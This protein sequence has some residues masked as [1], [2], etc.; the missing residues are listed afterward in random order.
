MSEI[1]IRY[2]NKI[3]NQTKMTTIITLQHYSR[4]S[5]PWQYAIKDITEV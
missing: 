4:Y 3:T 2:I 5:H 1:M